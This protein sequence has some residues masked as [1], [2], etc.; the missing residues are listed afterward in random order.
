MLSVQIPPTT[1]AAEPHITKLDGTF[2]QPW[3]YATYSDERWESEMQI[4]KETGIDYLIMGDV[5][6]HNTDGTWTVYYP[7]EL[8][9]LEGYYAYNA[10][11]NTIYMDT[12]TGIDA[13]ADALDEMFTMVIDH[14]NALDPDIPLLFSPYINIFGYGY[15]SINVDRF[16]E[17]Y[18]DVLSRIPFRDGDMLCPQDS[19][20]AGGCD[21]EH[22]AEWTKA[23]RNAVDRS[24]AIRGTELLLG[25][26]AEIFT[27]PDASRM[28]APTAFPISV[29]RPW[30]IL[31]SGWKLRS[32]MW[33]RSSA[34]HIRTTI[35]P[36]T[37][38]RNSTKFFSIT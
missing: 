32:P 11:D 7:S 23:Y 24:N 3:L 16:T 21:P 37:P 30:T 15:A 36:I 18:T 20:G 33:I 26:N 29:P 28:S 22:L 35:R 27:S 2:I 25:T 8:D 4:M 1:S 31:Q 5:A 17:Y 13:Y 19:C 34:L 9:F 38:C 14:C 12:D 6:N 10:I